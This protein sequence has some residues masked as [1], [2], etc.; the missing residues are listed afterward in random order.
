[1]HSYV[2]NVFPEMLLWSPQAKK[3]STDSR[4][5]QTQSRLHT[6]ALIPWLV[7]YEMAVVGMCKGQNPGASEQ[8]ECILCP[9]GAHV[10]VGDTGNK[11]GH[12]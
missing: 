8:T 3:A 7:L 4:E 6:Q 1:M 9:P 2:P 12:V 11:W 10:L 5:D